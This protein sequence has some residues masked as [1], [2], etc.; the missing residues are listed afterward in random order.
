VGQLGAAVLTNVQFV[1]VGE[2]KL[3][4]DHVEA[5]VIGVILLSFI[6]G[7]L[8]VPHSRVHIVATILFILAKNGVL[9]VVHIQVVV[10]I[11]IALSWIDEGKTASR[12]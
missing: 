9:T 6:D 1:L 2:S 10:A 4:I 12:R 7:T 5:E 3:V 8:A 11:R